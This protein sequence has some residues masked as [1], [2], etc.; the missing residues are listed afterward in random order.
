MKEIFNECNDSITDCIRNLFTDYEG[1]THIRTN[2]SSVYYANRKGE[3]YIIKIIVIGGTNDE[4]YDEYLLAHYESIIN[5]S[6]SD[7]F[8][9]IFDCKIKEINNYRF[10]F[11]V[12]EYITYTFQE[13]IEYLFKNFEN[14]VKLTA[15]N[16]MK[17]L[18]SL[19]VS[20]KHVGFQ[21]HRDLSFDNMRF[22][23]DYQLKMIDTASAKN[24]QIETTCFHQ[25]TPTKYFYASPEYTEIHIDRTEDGIVNSE[26]YTI[27]LLSGSLMGALRLGY[28]NIPDYKAQ[29]C[30]IYN[31]L[32][33]NKYHFNPGIQLPQ[34]YKNEY[35]NFLL[36]EV[37]RGNETDLFYR[38]LCSMVQESVSQRI[39][40]YEK[41]LD[42][43]GRCE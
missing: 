27:G 40:S 28:F 8:P 32:I 6:K 24:S 29:G 5:L 9:K 25:A 17:N 14:D 36:I 38:L 30:G 19:Y 11:I 16:F 18:L 33:E 22:T 34:R 15:I 21:A 7:A 35:F 2:V 1:I 4:N 26:I 20:S 12:E 43:L 42:I 13:G 37:F 39:H 3:K 31:W 41:I 10:A 23:S